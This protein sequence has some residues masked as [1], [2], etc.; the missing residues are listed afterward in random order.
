MNHHSLLTFANTSF[1]NTDRI[2]AEAAELGVFRNIFSL[3]ETNIPEFIEKHKE[4][5]EIIKHGY[6]A[7]IWKPYIVLKTLE[8]LPENHT[9]LYC[10]AGMHINSM[11][12][13]RYMEYLKMLETDGTDVVVFDL[14]DSFKTED[15]VKRDAV[16]SYYPEL[17]NQSNKYCYAGMFLVKNTINVR[18]MIHEWLSLCESYHY[19]LNTPS[20]NHTEIPGYRGND[21]DC[22][23]FNMCILKNEKIVKR[24]SPNETNIFKED[25]SQH[26]ECTDWSSLDTFPLQVRRIR[27]K[28]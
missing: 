2:Q 8:K 15:F 19:L 4:F 18:T 27:P 14:P 11:G 20:M 28:K 21:G 17:Y 13:A 16:M 1:M 22:G 12:K 9:L 25:G 24:I 23:L 7:W 3:N 10:D 6:G 5:I 26:Y